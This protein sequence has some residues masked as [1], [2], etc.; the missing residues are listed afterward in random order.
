MLSNY[1]CSVLMR[2]IYR[3]CKGD[4]C[5]CI[6]LNGA[7]SSGVVSAVYIGVYIIL[8]VACTIR[9]TQYNTT[10]INN[11]NMRSAGFVASACLPL[12]CFIR[13]QHSHNNYCRLV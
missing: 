3:A 5:T 7:L 1:I 8:Y 13:F 12:E 6:Y 4:W 10:L 2:L 11:I 9:S